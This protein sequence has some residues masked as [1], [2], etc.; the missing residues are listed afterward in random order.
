VAWVAALAVLASCAAPPVPAT[1]IANV[2]TVSFEPAL[3]PTGVARSNADLAEDFLD[4]TFALES[5]QDLPGLLRYEG[6]VRVAIRSPQLR[7][8]ARDIDALVARFR[9]EAGIDISRVGD[10][11]AQIHLVAVPSAQ[12]QRAYP[13]AACF[14]VPGESSWEG[15][16]SKPRRQRLRWSDQTELGTTAIFIPSDASPQD[17]RDCLNE[18]LAQALGTANDI[19]RLPD[20]VF[21]DDN[22]HSVVTPFDMLMLRVLYDPT[23]RSGMSRGAVA[24]QL[25]AILDTANPAGRG[26]G[27]SA[28]APESAAWKDAIE[29]AMTRGNPAFQRRRGAETAVSLAAA[30]S[31]RDHR[32]GV[33][34]L[35]R[36]RL[37][38]RD[39]P[40]SAAKDFANAY[41]VFRSRLGEDDIR[42]AQAALHVA[43]IA[44]KDGN[45]ALARSL[46]DRAVPA[47][48]AGENAVLAS[49]LYAIRAEALAGA[50]QRAEAQRAR[51]DSLKWARLAFGDADG[52][53]AAAQAELEMPQDL[54]G[55]GV[56]G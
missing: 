24:L 39:S 12:I 30:M 17:I 10:G 4:L 37:N 48:L 5:G 56:G 53:I 3:R 44:L 2:T 42:T 41:S 34:L 18:E 46:A 27:R 19:Y 9:R 8:Y 49:G 50:G 43:I 25:P 21:N 32:L 22:F 51:V 20:S 36:G 13:G 15:F 11:S 16:R 35:T 38:L 45:Y 29:A 40:A 55:E 14:I 6:P 31:P 52:A 28:R 26:M 1:R 47:A 23:L 33:A 7:P 54:R